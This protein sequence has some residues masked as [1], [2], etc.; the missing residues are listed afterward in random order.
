MAGVR[1]TPRVKGSINGS[2][3]GNAIR[4]PKGKARCRLC[5]EAKEKRALAL[6][7]AETASKFKRKQNLS[8][9]D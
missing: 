8:L 3:A 4:S 7:G 2:R 6:A 9:Q 5:D 1:P